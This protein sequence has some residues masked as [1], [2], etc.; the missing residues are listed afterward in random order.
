LVSL[1][2]LGKK[3][4][5]DRL[6]LLVLKDQKD[7]VDQEVQMD[8]PVLLANLVTVVMQDQKDLKDS[9]GHWRPRVSR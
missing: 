1:D 9:L 7:N 3:D 5:V 8:N 6:E 2:Q 4:R